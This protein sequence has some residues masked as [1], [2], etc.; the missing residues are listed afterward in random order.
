MKRTIEGIQ[1]EKAKLTPKLISGS[2]PG[3][4]KSRSSHRS[5]LPP[6][7]QRKAN[8]IFAPQ[9]RDN[10]MAQPTHSLS[11]KASQ[12]R[13]APLSLVMAHQQ[14]ARPPGPKRNER[15]RVPVVPGRS[16]PQASSSSTE[17]PRP[18]SE[19]KGS[20]LAEQEAPLKAIATGKPLPAENVGEEHKAQ[21]QAPAKEASPPV[22]K[23]IVKRSTISPPVDQSQPASADGNAP[24]AP[25]KTAPS[26]AP[27]RP[28]VIRRRPPADP[29][30]RPKQRRRLF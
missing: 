25:E 7:A 22:K 21:A 18:M 24:P 20:S 23:P 10:V 26:N 16:T 5:G 30:L 3:L 28:P 11:S 2:V 6:S 15:I 12:V 27:P 9:K 14:P 8:N 4:R 19:D 17:S 13:Q 29:L 1:S